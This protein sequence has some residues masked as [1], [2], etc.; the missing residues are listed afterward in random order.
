VKIR[1]FFSGFNISA[2]GMTAQRKRMNA[3]AENVANAETTRTEEGV[4]YRRKVVVL[5]SQAVQSFS[6]LMNSAGLPLSATEPGHFTDAG[7][8]S[9]RVDLSA[10]G[11]TATETTDNTP[12][13]RVYDPGHPDADA[14]GYV[15]MPNVNVV[16]EMVDMISASRSYEAN[17]TA[18]TAA[19]TM[20]KDALEI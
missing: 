7:S 11:V 16:T 17:V 19:K 10:D 2:M 3:I 13:K 1:D 20:A 12:Y 9:G 15:E 14:D 18:V 5:R 8:E 4:A 6:N